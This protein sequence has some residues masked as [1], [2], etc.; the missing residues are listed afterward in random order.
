MVR[1]L[2]RRHRGEDG[3]VLVFLPGVN[4]IRKA[5]RELE[6]TRGLWVLPLHGALSGADQRRVFQRPPQGQRK[7]VLSTN[8]AETSVTIDDIVFVVDT[9]RMKQME[10]DPYKKMSALVETWVSHQNAK[11]RQD[12][13]RKRSF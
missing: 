10:Y 6:G 7:V 13:V 12:Q 3:A 11:Q 2:H 9:G 5:L 8:V 1:D 4:E